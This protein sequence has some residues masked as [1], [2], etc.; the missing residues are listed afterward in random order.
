[1]SAPKPSITNLTVRKQETPCRKRNSQKE[2]KI[3]CIY[4]LSK[5]CHTVEDR[6]TCYLQVKFYVK[7]CTCKHHEML[8]KMF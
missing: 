4:L 6:V 2:C 1:M 7:E 3:K 5:Q 8:S